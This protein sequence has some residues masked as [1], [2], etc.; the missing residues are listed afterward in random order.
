MSEGQS[1]RVDGVGRGKEREGRREPVNFK[2]SRPWSS[3]ML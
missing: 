3:A 1:E 2:D